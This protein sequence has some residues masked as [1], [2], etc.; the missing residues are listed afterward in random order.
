MKR[1]LFVD[2]EPR[3]L[4]QLQQMLESQND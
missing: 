4:E 3:V 1:D 2:D